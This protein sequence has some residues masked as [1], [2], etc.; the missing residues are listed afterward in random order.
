MM[1]AVTINMTIAEY[2]SLMEAIP[3][4]SEPV[5]HKDVLVSDMAATVTLYISSP[6]VLFRLALTMNNVDRSNA[7]DKNAGDKDNG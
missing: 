4:F 3:R 2:N 7:E 1:M 6:E 5:R